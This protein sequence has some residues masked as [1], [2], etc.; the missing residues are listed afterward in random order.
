M[1]TDAR[2]E[3]T[4]SVISMA[5]Q[6][7][8]RARA[9]TTSRDPA[10]AVSA[11]F[12]VFH[13]VD[14][15]C[16]RF[17]PES[18][19]MRANRCGEQWVTVDRRCYDALVEAHTAYRRT[20]GRFDPRVLD[21]LVRLGYEHSY[22]R[23][24]PAP[25][26]PAGALVPRAALQPWRPGFR[27]ATHEV[28]IGSRAV[29]LGGIGKG[30][31]V[32]WAAQV[33]ADAGVRDAV[34]EAGGDCFCAGTPADASRWRVGV[35]DPRGGDDPVAVV[36]LADEA[37][38]TSSVR[39]R[40]W[41]I[42]DRA[43]HHLVDPATGLPGGEGLLSVTVV[44]DDPATAEVWSKVLFLT[45]ARGVATMADLYALA[46]LWVDTDGGVR[47]SPAM[48]SRLAWTGAP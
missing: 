16:T 42:G 30:L 9:T 5:S 13:D 40:T 6:V 29:D 4:D 18:D 48:S 12:E 14:R 28:Q 8:I 3:V 27:A 10:R 38:A 43:V 45:G 25:R 11:A 44:D 24:V 15:T 17:D 34:V 39:L 36:E 33:L 19:L 1:L 2:A 41:R 31:A 46:A 35:E 22:R 20:L 37:V 26:D 7:T 47:S 21:D 23:A 32:R